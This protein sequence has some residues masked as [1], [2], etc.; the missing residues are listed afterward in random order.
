MV[1]ALIRSKKKNFTEKKNE[2]SK[3][4]EYNQIYHKRPHG[5]NQVN[6]S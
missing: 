5:N 1:Q 2:E 6:K 4:T 3:T